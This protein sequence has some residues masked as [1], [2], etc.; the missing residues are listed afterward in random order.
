MSKVAREVSYN[1]PKIGMLLDAI[2]NPSPPSYNISS[3]RLTI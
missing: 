2:P 1:I 3:S